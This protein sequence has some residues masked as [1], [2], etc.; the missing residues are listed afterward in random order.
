M[1]VKVALLHRT[2]YRFAGAVAL[3]PH[4]V[5][6]RPAPYARARITAYS[7][8]VGPVAHRRY[9]QLDPFGNWQARLI[10]A[11]PTEQLDITV[12]LRAEIATVDPFDFFVEPAVETWP[13]AYE[14]A[15]ALD[16]APYL[17]VEP[18]GRHFAQ[19]LAGISREPCY[20][21]TFLVGLNRRLAE[22]I[23]HLVR[24]E[25]GI[26]TIEETLEKG[27]GS[28]RD[29]AWLLVQLCRRLGLAAR[30][31]SGY[32]IQLAL[33]PEAADGPDRDLTDLHA[34]AEVY[35][36]G[37]GWIG[38]DPTSGMLT[39]EGHVPLAASPR[40]DHATPIEGTA[41][42]PAASFDV[43]MTIG[44]LHER[45][46]PIR[47]FVPDAW[48][49]IEG[50]QQTIA[51]R[52]QATGLEL[53]LGREAGERT[54]APV[55]DPAAELAEVEAL[56]DGLEQGFYR[57]DGQPRAAPPAPIAITLPVTER[58]DLVASLVR[59][60]QAHPALSYFFA[61]GGVG[62]EGPAPR[63]D[64]LWADRLV[65]LELALAAVDRHGAS[66]LAGL[67]DLL[68][69]RTG[70]PVGG[71]IAVDAAG[72]VRLRSFALPPHPRMTALQHLFVRAVL[73][74]LADS[75]VRSGLVP[76]GPAL[77]DRWFL[78]YWLERDLDVVVGE[79][80]AAGLA[81]ERGWL[82]AEAAF[83]H[84]PLG[85]RTVAG[86]RLAL[87]AALEPPRLLPLE[88]GVRYLDDS[89]DRVELLVTGELA[90]HWTVACN[91]V[92]VPLTP[93]PDG[94]WVAGIRYR[95]R[96]LP[97]MMQPQVAPL[98]RLCVEL[99]DERESR[100]LGG[101]TLHLGTADGGTFDVPP[102]NDLAAEARRLARFEAMGHTVG[103]MQPR[104][105]PPD[106]L[107]PHT[108]DL[109]RVAG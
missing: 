33:D 72:Q 26:Q 47:P 70:D 23:G 95:A 100:S 64:L 20:T 18:V 39:G 108:F 36:P 105:L 60:W 27:S 82:A 38:L 42:R 29:T 1:S 22:R 57:P 10:F 73:L 45:P 50:L 94:G 81:F 25:P 3:G 88:G 104:R 106:P 66:A 61:G 103:M 87:R 67:R 35:L 89:L 69:D 91:G 71:E 56:H 16:L 19:L 12:D 79:L 31:V 58:P 83:R 98:D 24:L 52:A 4:L 101:C 7:L 21:V 62:A 8:E 107:H 43:E 49:A 93:T 78:P 17:E 74:R 109:R 80:A 77:Q 48:A 75:P 15:L 9:W 34:W 13:F 30:F 65:E 28:C 68:T 32:L 96:A 99:V 63:A 6:L 46:R 53:R 37:A 92:A 90:A 40:P 102:V 76:H 85:S 84:P 5:R 59:Y 2:R 44:R 51:E 97:R 55:L 11:E 41:E 86:A 14:P 54:M